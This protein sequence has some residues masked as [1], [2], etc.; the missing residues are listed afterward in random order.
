MGRIAKW[1]LELMG[2]NIAYAP[3]TAIKSQVLADIMAE[4][5]EE[6]ASTAP[7]KLEY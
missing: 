2:L 7:T 1:G 4:W 5:T 6:E 3:G